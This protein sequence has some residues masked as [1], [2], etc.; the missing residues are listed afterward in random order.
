MSVFE[1]PGHNSKQ[2]SSE[3]NLDMSESEF[4]NRLGLEVWSSIDRE[5]SGDSGILNEYLD[6]NSDSNASE[7]LP[8][9]TLS[10]TEES[11]FVS[12]NTEEVTRTS[13]MPDTNPGTTEP[14]SESHDL[15][16]NFREDES[17]SV[18]YLATARSNESRPEELTETI[19]QF[20]EGLIAGASFAD[21][22]TLLDELGENTRAFSDPH[23]VA[24]ALNESINNHELQNIYYATVDDTG[25][26]VLGERD[27]KILGSMHVLEELE[28]SSQVLS[29]YPN[30]D[31]ISQLAAGFADRYGETC[32]SSSLNETIELMTKEG[33]NASEIESSLNWALD[34][35][36]LSNQ[37]IVAYHDRVYM[38][39][40]E[41]TGP[42]SSELASINSYISEPLT[43]AEGEDNPSILNYEPVDGVFDS[44]RPLGLGGLRLGQ[45]SE[46]L[47]NGSRTSQF[48]TSERSQRTTYLY[49]GVL[50]DLEV[51]DSST[52]YS[53]SETIGR[54]GEL[55]R[56]RI[57]YEIPLDLEF[58]GPGDESVAI[59]NVTSVESSIR[60]DQT[61]GSVVTTS[62]GRDIVFIR[63]GSGRVVRLHRRMSF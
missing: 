29:P 60:A 45:A 44:A 55:V 31:S 40:G 53:G 59:R 56:S 1:S 42:N 17:C 34:A 18:G 43:N 25:N 13:S 35:R 33:A 10:L 20:V 9:V 30:Q 22:Q 15:D 41:Y 3:V 6:K 11:D 24:R 28:Q 50:E 47:S 57:E 7:F 52:E 36:G 51:Q 61:L 37:R 27:L 46:D 8:E 32:D 49:Q 23:L 58:L 19:D 39:S 4:P 12:D 2:A 26:L 62:D 5:M 16:S 63:D 14:N 48:F 38:F 21:H 54:D